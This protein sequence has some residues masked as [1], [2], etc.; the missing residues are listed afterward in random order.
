MKT[1]IFNSILFL[2][3]PFFTNG[4]TQLTGMVKTS[5]GETVPGVSVFLKGTYDGTTTDVDGKFAFETQETGLQILAFQAMGFKSQELSINLNE[6][7]PSFSIILKE[8]IN[9]LTAVTISAGAMEASDEKKAVVLR[10]LDIVTTPS[11]MGDI[12]GAFQTLP[13]T[14]TVG[15]DGRLFVR[16]GDASETAIFIDGMKVG[17][18][19]GTTANNVPTRTRFNPNLFKGSFFSTGG[20]SAEYGQALSSALALQTIDLPLRNQ[21]DIS[22]MSVGMGYTQTLAGEKSSLTASAN[23]MDLSPYQA[24]IKQNF[25]WERSPYS[26]DAEVSARRKW[27]KNGMV[28]AYLHTEAGGMQL[29][30]PQPGQEGRGQMITIHNRYT[31]AQTSFR[32][33]GK[34]DWNYYGGISYSDNSDKI[35][36]NTIDVKQRNRLIHGKIVGVKG[37]S[38]RF[39]IKNG[40]ETFTHNYV[41]HLVEEGLSRSYLDQQV[42]I[43]T[44]TDYY[45]S[46]KMV[47]RGGLRSG[48]SSLAGEGWLDPRVSLAYKLENEGQFSFAAGTF[49]QL[50]LEQQ[51]VINPEL[52]NTKASHLILNYFIS[53]SGRTFRAEAFHKDYKQLVT[54]EGL[55]QAAL[56]LRQDGA[57]YAGGMDVFYRDR[58]TIKN[59]DFWITYSYVNSRRQFAHFST[60]VQ[61]GFAPVHNGSVVV[62]HFIPKLQSQLGTSSSFNDGYTFTDLNH[63]G[64][65]NSKTKSF[66][67]LSISWSYLPKPNLIIHLACS[68]VLG[69]NN[70]FGHQFTQEP[71]E[72]GQFESLPI[73]QGAPRF[74]FLGIFLTLSKDKT[75]NQLNNL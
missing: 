73:R 27:G 36:L 52:G 1:L 14:S 75:A 42:N 46:S 11:A 30:Q 66:Q 28:K 7:A 22:L 59:T 12:I 33:S 67:D 71:N 40:L 4:Q 6:S 25:D 5:Y 21:G 62:K 55:P 58:K 51:R 15:N 39:S 35:N 26:W 69:R 2:L 56:N 13:G 32:Q 31:F 74:L 72:A 63:P 20:Y 9:E 17:N 43:F 3:L 54:F 41:E 37:F 68:N 48:Y 60:K 45:F 23:F 64:E 47:F 19:F 44:E 38:D 18:A 57:G 61:P 34:K 10:P 70:I 16:G 24:L 65:M 8:S 29:W 49:S 50:P 53:K